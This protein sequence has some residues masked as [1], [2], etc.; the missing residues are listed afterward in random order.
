MV[1]QILKRIVMAFLIFCMLMVTTGDRGAEAS[2]IPVEP[3]ITQQ[4]SVLWAGIAFVLGL[5]VDAT[6]AGLWASGGVGSGKEPT[7][8]PIKKPDKQNWVELGMW[9]PV[10]WEYQFEWIDEPSLT[11]EWVFFELYIY[12]NDREI[13]FERY[14]EQGYIDMPGLN[15]SCRKKISGHFDIAPRSWDCEGNNSDTLRIEAVIWEDS[16][17][18]T[19]D[20][21][22]SHW[23]STKNT[24]QA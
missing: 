23:I 5:V 12:L 19:H 4:P 15:D 8:T 21:K 6:Q 3:V 10:E 9:N 2:R 7:I 1:K 18:K 24:L 16:W 20:K 17:R 22:E 14:P 11:S 13:L